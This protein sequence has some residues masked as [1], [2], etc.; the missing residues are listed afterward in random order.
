MTLGSKPGRRFL[1][2]ISERKALTVFHP[3]FDEKH[4]HY[5]TSRSG[6]KFQVGF[7]VVRQFLLF[8]YLS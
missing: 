1:I 6:Q 8:L 7:K 5:W 4:V 2:S 3:I